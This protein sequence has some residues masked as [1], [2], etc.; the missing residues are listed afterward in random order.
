MNVERGGREAAFTLIELLVVVAMIAV[1]A[2]LLLVGAG[3]ALGA[4]ASARCKSNLRQLSMELHERV[5]EAGFYPN[6]GLVIRRK[7]GIGSCPRDKHPPIVRIESGGTELAGSYGYNLF[8]GG[9]NGHIATGTNTAAST[10]ENLGLLHRREAEIKNPSGLISI[11]GSYTEINHG[12]MRTAGTA[13]VNRTT[14][15]GYD[16]SKLTDG[17]DVDARTRHKNYLNAA[18]CDEHVESLTVNALFL[19]KSEKALCRWN[20]DDEAHLATGAPNAK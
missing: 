9:T 14:P 11:T 16:L 19:Q 6:F 7:N 18:F 4:A 13:G 1:L 5:S 8:G 12:I 3:H 20:Y 10:T 2:A 17:G 15:S